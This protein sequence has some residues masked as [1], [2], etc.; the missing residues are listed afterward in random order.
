MATSFQN[1]K[2]ALGDLLS[3]MSEATGASSR[4]TSRRGSGSMGSVISMDGDDDG[5]ILDTDFSLDLDN[6]NEIASV[7]STK[8]TRSGSVRS[9]KVYEKENARNQQRVFKEKKYT[10]T[11]VTRRQTMDVPAK[12]SDNNSFHYSVS[13]EAENRRQ[14]I[15]PVLISS[16]LDEVSADEDGGEVMKE[17]P[18]KGKGEAS[19]TSEMETSGLTDFSIHFDKS[20]DESMF[21]KASSQLSPFSQTV[22]SSGKRNYS[23][24]FESSLSLTIFLFKY[25]ILDVL[26][27]VHISL[28]TTTRCNRSPANAVQKSSHAKTTTSP[29][30]TPEGE[31]SLDL[32]PRLGD[33]S[34]ERVAEERRA[35]LD[36][37]D[38]DALLNSTDSSESIS[39]HDLM[40]SVEK[41]NSYPKKD[42][43]PTSSTSKHLPG[44]GGSRHQSSSRSSQLKSSALTSLL[45][46]FDESTSSVTS[47][48]PQSSSRR[49]SSGISSQSNSMEDVV[50]LPA[51]STLEAN[52]STDRVTA[53]QSAIAAMMKSIDNACSGTHTDMN[54]ADETEKPP[55]RRSPRLASARCSPAPSSVKS[56]HSTKKASI[57]EPPSTKSKGSRRVSSRS[58]TD[59]PVSPLTPAS[60]Y[61]RRNLAHSARSSYSNVAT[62]AS[63]ENSTA[64]EDPLQIDT[65]EMSDKIKSVDSPGRRMT[66]EAGSIERFI[67]ELDED[68][69]GQTTDN[70]HDDRR[71]TADG[72]SMAALL[73][74]LE[75]EEE[76]G[77][78]SMLSLGS[79]GKGRGAKVEY[80]INV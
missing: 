2:A 57:H 62:I 3:P 36:P 20:G 28:L 65:S 75:E 73:A 56:S 21:S 61:S 51:I 38:F 76:D 12:S 55:S 46:G 42:M 50:L 1:L 78:V 27:F 48:A 60:T 25:Y 49:L 54:D 30:D 79:V 37:T 14:T 15:D 39:A 10:T 80:L 16:I 43:T 35:T 74:N 67:N 58:S 22:K 31:Q 33:I 68:N 59:A 6:D 64:D 8:S 45:T 53:D 4:R 70:T 17:I 29:V 9:S 7:G 41:R 77:R 52:E 24:R 34:E 18:S 44:S 23:K 5:K 47:S 66:V 40:T 26:L 32:F 69:V 72:A 13:K 71:L 63:L 19:D 11:T